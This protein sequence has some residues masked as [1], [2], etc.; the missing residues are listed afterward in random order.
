MDCGS[1][2]EV[3]TAVGGN[4]KALAAK[5]RQKTQ[6]EVVVCDRRKMPC[7]KSG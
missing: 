4:G 1:A 6:F 2:V 5:L 3:G 7:L